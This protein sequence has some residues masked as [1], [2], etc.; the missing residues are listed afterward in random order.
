MRAVLLLVAAM[1]NTVEGSKAHPDLTPAMASYL[2]ANMGSRVDAVM[3]IEG[4]VGPDYQ[5][6]KAYI[7]SGSQYIKWDLNT[8]TFYS[9]PKDIYSMYGG[10]FSHVDA[11]MPIIGNVGP[12]YQHNKAYIFFGSQYV[13]WDLNTDTFYSGP[14]NIY[15][16][17]GGH[18][19][20]VDAVMPIIGNV[21]PS[22]QHNKA[23][24]FFGSQ[25][26]KWDLNTDTFYSG[27]KDIYSMYGGHFSHVDAVMP[28]IGNV[29]PSYMHN[30]AYIFFGNQYVK[31][32]LNTDSFYSGPKDIDSNFPGI[33]TV[34]EMTGTIKSD[35]NLAERI[36]NSSIGLVLVGGIA[37]AFTVVAMIR[38]KRQPV[39][40]QAGLLGD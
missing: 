6:N 24:I 40:L 16:M 23:Y 29:G 4:N 3:T 8:D 26:V 11:V 36:T 32:D 13:K 30:K 27:P 31:W 33:P 35:E 14:K 7:F 34:S 5:H 18:F 37:G 1:L 21:G 25:Y 38:F 9:G 15:S 22:Y 17:Y 12:S 10:H 39:G 19:S 28:V 20:H 2:A